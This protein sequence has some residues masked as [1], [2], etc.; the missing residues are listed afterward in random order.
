MVPHPYTLSDAF[1][2]IELVERLKNQH[3]ELTLY[4]I[5][6]ENDEVIGGIGRK[7]QNGPDGK[8]DEIGY[9]LGEPFW[10]KGIMTK[11]LNKYCEY[12][13]QELG[14]SRIE[15]TIFEHNDASARLLK[16]V[17]FEKGEILPEYYEKNGE[18]IDAIR[19]YKEC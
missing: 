14:L 1:Q 18:K 17:E 8:V 12:C 13:F 4:S 10:G 3:N 5:R 15:A 11:V 9:W 19:Y 16:R 7:V 6:D 2:F